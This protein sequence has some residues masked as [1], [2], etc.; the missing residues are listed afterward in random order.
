M[1]YHHHLEPVLVHQVDL[2]N[3]PTTVEDQHLTNAFFVFST[4]KNITLV[5]E[6]E[7]ERDQ[8]VNAIKETVDYRNAMSDAEI[9]Y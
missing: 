5:S 4:T 7:D 1:V 8:W 3:V 6:T 2:K 9:K